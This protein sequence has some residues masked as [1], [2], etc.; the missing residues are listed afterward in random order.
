MNYAKTEHAE[1]ARKIS[2]RTAIVGVIGLG[3][4]GLPLAINLHRA[5][6]SVYGFDSDQAKIDAL[7]RGESYLAHMDDQAFVDLTESDDFYAT[8]DM[9]EMNKVDV[10]ISCVP[11][12][13]G[14]HREPDLGFVIRSAQDI[15]RSLRAGMLI[16]L[17]ST[18]YPGTTRLEFLNA[19][20]EVAPGPFVLGED[21][22]VAYSPERE[23]PGRVSHQS[24]EVA[25][26]VGGLDP[27]SG[28]LAE[29]L[30]EAAYVK[31][32]RVGSAE[33]AEAAKILENVF[34]AVNIAL[35]NELKVVFT[36]L[37]IDIWEVIEAASSK[38]Y[39]FMPFFPG[40]WL[41]GH[42]IPIDPFY[43]S[44]KAKEVGRPT[45]FIELAGMINTQMPGYVI[46]RLAHALND[47]GKPV[48]GSRVLVLGLAYKSNVTDTRESPTFE[49]IEDLRGRGAL[50]DYHDPLIPET[51]PTRRH[52][53]GLQSVAL[54]T[55]SVAGYDAVLIATVHDAMDLAV[56]ARHAQLV[57]DTRNAMK[58]FRSIV[59]DRLVS[60]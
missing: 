31:V 14:P 34:R 48:K 38:P 50:V 17:E 45:Q 22:F 59:G 36:D 49:L 25:K 55:E 60:A 32:I 24:A 20:L 23:D 42:C 41:G 54:T 26:L 51:I 27:T 5:G 15:G 58:P 52:D 7:E 43:L 37:G 40:P 13:L 29:R 18:T 9:T 16:V 47:A 11:T 44:W 4:V 2:D 6:F 53:L 57:V 19:M 10:V 1:L 3:Y 21:I 12:P 28:D 46:D 33:V 35:V 30:Y 8:S 56:V 39:G